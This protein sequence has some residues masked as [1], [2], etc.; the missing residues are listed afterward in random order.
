MRAN[1]RQESAL[2]TGGRRPVLST[3]APRTQ[4]DRFVTTLRRKRRRRRCQDLLEQSRPV[5]HVVLGGAHVDG[6][7]QVPPAGPATANPTRTPAAGARAAPPNDL[8]SSASAAERPRLGGDAEPQLLG[9]A[10]A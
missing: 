2:G 8:P 6:C 5:G 9:D 3:R 4:T 1:S 10:P 7:A